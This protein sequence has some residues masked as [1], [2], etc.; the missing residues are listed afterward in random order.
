MFYEAKKFNR[1]VSKWNTGAVTSMQG[2]KYTPPLSV[3]TPSAVVYM[4]FEYTCTT[5]R[6]SSDHNSHILTRLVTCTCIFVFFVFLFLLNVVGW[7]FL[8]FVAPSLLVFNSASAFNQDV[9]KWNTGAVTI[10]TYS[11]CTLLLPLPLWPRLPSL[12]ILNIRRL[13]FYRITILTRFV[14]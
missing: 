7:S 12:C 13:K 11:K 4:Y 5:T 3:I 6:D 10:M 8:F 2:S 9:S 14:I 1:G